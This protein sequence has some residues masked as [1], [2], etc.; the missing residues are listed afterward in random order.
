MPGFRFLRVYRPGEPR[1]KVVW[2]RFRTTQ[3][4][5]YPL[6]S[7]R[8]G[9]RASRQLTILRFACPYRWPVAL[10]PGRRFLIGPIPGVVP[11]AQNKSAAER[12]WEV[13]IRSFGEH[14]TEIVSAEV[15][16]K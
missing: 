5:K 1:P 9:I 8:R 10:T 6:G 3:P 14:L 16:K 2:P 13:F 11:V 12:P 7:I 15:F 4:C